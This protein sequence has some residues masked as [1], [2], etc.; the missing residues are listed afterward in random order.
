[1]PTQHYPSFP[2]FRPDAEG[3]SQALLWLENDRHETLIMVAEA[4]SLAQP[5]VLLRLVTAKV[6]FTC[7]STVVIICIF[8]PINQG[9]SMPIALLLPQIGSSES[10]KH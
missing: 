2:C 10:W 4:G 7:W 1:M 6:Q 5:R 3:G 8:V 9:Y